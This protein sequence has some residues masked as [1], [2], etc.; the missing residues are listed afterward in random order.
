MFVFVIL[1][2]LVLLYYV[3][4]FDEADE[5]RS[6]VRRLAAAVK[7]AKHL[8]VYTGAGISTVC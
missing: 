5:L 8:V 2:D 4:V 3:Q 7:Q 6:K 1:K